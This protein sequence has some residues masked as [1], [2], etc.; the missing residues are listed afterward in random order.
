MSRPYRRTI[1]LSASRQGKAA[2]GKDGP[3]QILP[4]QRSEEGSS[5]KGKDTAI[6]GS[7]PVSGSLGVAGNANDRLHKDSVRR[8]PPKRA[9]PKLKTPPSAAANQ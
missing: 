7:Q 6:G 4:T 2:D 5:T 9:L 8:D 3:V 1:L